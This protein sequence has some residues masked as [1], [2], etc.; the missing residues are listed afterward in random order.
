MQSVAKDIANRLGIEGL[1][2][3]LRC[4]NGFKKDTK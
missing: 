2:C 4:I 1:K 3:S